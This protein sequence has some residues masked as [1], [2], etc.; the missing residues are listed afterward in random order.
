MGNKEKQALKESNQDSEQPHSS[1]NC[2]SLVVAVYE[3]EWFVGEICKEQNFIPTGY[4][5][6]SYTTPR[7]HNVFKWPDRKDIML[8]L[9]EDI[10]LKN[11]QVGP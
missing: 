3:G 8:T 7:G 2:G 9:E 6:V 1:W 10:I 5:R 11:V 4:K